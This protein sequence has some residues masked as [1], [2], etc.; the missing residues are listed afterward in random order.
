MYEVLSLSMKAA[1]QPQEEIDRAIMSAAEFTQ[2][3]ADLMYLGDYLEQVKMDR[4][5]LQIYHQVAQAEPLWPEPYYR[6]MV[7]AQNLNDQPG[8]EWSTAGILG[9]AFQPTQSGIWEKAYLIAKAALDDL[10]KTKRTDGPTASRPS[11][12]SQ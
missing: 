12:M 4:R 9:Q 7:V 3:S 10:R 6:G 2:N 1:G 11:L 5:A 8:L